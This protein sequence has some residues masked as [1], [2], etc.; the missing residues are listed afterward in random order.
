MLRRLA[1]GAFVVLVSTTAFA[2]PA[3]RDAGASSTADMDPAVELARLD[4]GARRAETSARDGR[5]RASTMSAVARLAKSKLDGLTGSDRAEVEE[6]L[7]HLQAY[8]ATVDAAARGDERAAAEY[9]ALADKLRGRL[10]A[11][12]KADNSPCD[13]AFSFDAEGHKRWKPE[14]F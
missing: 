10:S 13:P 8:V 9:R 12:G 3:P 6:G 2:D 11:P 4:L 5:A 1:L 7:T 14:C